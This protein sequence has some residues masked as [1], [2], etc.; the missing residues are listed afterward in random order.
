M[1]MRQL[2]LDDPRWLAFVEAQPDAGP[3]HH[4]AW[5]HLVASTYGFRPFAHALEED[6]CIVAGLPTAELRGLSGARR[7]VSLPFTDELTPLVA[8]GVDPGRLIEAVWTLDKAPDAGALV[9][10]TVPR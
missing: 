2:P 3:F 7:W 1:T 10:L 6:G 9:R 4:P 5:G 8:P